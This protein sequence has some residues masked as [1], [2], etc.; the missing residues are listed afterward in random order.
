MVAADHVLTLDAEGTTAHF[1]LGATGHDV[2]GNLYLKSGELQL[3]A[4]GT[5]SGQV[6]L[7]AVK[8]ETGNK[9]RDKKMHNEVLV[10]DKN[11]MIVFEAEGWSGDLAS[12]GTSDFEISGTMTLVGQGHAMTLPI[13]LE[14]K[15]GALEG[16]STFSVPF[17]EWGLE[18]PSILFLSVAKEVE[19]TIEAVGRLASAALPEDMAPS[20]DMPQDANPAPETTQDP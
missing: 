20:D 14:V 1:A 16:N 7:D 17:I 2:H 18:D 5:A 10:S 3:A 8:T 13:H 15:D 4:D 9:R 6:V 12:E 11:P 19:V